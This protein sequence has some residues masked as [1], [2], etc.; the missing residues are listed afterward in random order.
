M[1]LSDNTEQLI[2]TKEQQQKLSNEERALLQEQIRQKMHIKYQ[3]YYKQW[4]DFEMLTM[5]LA[6]VGVILAIVEVLKIT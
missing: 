5:I 1:Q 4:R 3:K 2:P 6:I